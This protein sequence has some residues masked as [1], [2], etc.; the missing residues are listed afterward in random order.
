MA[1]LAERQIP[2]RVCQGSNLALGLYASMEQ[3]P[4]DTLRRAGVLVSV[5]NDDPALFGTSQVQ[6]YAR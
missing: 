6:D 5:N 3:H 2:L 1:L 4:I